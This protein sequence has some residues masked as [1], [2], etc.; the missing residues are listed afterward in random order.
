MVSIHS[1]TIAWAW[2][3]C[4]STDSPDAFQVKL[5]AASGVYSV[6]ACYSSSVFTASLRDLLSTVGIV[7][8]VVIPS[9]Q[10]TPLCCTTEFT[11]TVSGKSVMVR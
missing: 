1:G 3:A 7:Y 5:G 2:T 10:T 8:G 6:C 4:G 9:R 11:M